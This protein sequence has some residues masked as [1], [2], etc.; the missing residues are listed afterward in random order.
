MANSVPMTW[1]RHKAVYVYDHDTFYVHDHDDE[2][3]VVDMDVN[4][5]VVV[6]VIVHVDGLQPATLRRSSITA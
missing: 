2:N 4:V 3:V 5:T 1:L 6:N